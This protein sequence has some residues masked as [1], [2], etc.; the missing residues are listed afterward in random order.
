MFASEDTIEL[1][2]DDST[3][4]R[5]HSMLPQQQ[6]SIVSQLVRFVL[7]YKC[8]DQLFIQAM[9]CY[10][11]LHDWKNAENWIKMINKLEQSNNGTTSNRA[12]N[13]Q[14]IQQL[15]ALSS[16]DSEEMRSF[17]GVVDWNREQRIIKTESI[18]AVALRRTDN[19]RN[20]SLR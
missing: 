1:S 9:Q 2:A 5:S 8:I 4:H 18:L 6:L 10:I 15:K 12:I 16:F 17:A 13:N 3:T 7:L 14:Q 19:G 20:H 11:Q